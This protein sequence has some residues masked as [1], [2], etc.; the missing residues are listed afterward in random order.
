M[1]DAEPLDEQLRRY[2]LATWGLT[3]VPSALGSIIFVLLTAFG[4][5]AIGALVAG[6]LFL[7]IIAVAWLD[8]R[9]LE[10]AVRDYEEEASGIAPV[11][12]EDAG[13]TRG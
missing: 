13:A 7:P 4:A 9:R 6:L 8:Y 12:A 5:P 1:L 2:R 3:A 11:P 10:R